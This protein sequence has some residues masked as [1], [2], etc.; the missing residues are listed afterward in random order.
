[1]VVQLHDAEIRRKRCERIIGDLRRSFRDGSEQRRL[2]SVW[3]T[4]ETDIGDELELERDLAFLTF[5]AR[6]PIRRRL[7]RWCSK[8]FVAASTA[9]A[10]C[11]QQLLTVF[12][13][14][15]EYV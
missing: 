7:A 15:T 14:F 11:N 8:R 12:S 5:F 9:T 2:A 13:D 4:N 1:M 10:F 3:F 6:L